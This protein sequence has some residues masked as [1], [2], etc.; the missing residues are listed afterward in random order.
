[1]E[2]L[3]LKDDDSVTAFRLQHC[4]EI[5]RNS[6]TGGSPSL[7]TG[8]PSICLNIDSS[9][10]LNIVVSLNQACR[11]FFFYSCTF[12]K[13]PIYFNSICILIIIRKIDYSYQCLVYSSSSHQQEGLK[14]RL[15]HCLNTT[16]ICRFPWLLIP[17][18]HVQQAGL[19]V[20]I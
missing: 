18:S 9:L 3:L 19:S 2:N 1:M 15:L 4:M 12:Y 11:Y 6:T 13:C 14:I 5:C 17:F 7:L 16:K 20:R 8:R 10:L